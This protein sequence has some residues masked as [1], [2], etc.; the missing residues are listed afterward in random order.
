MEDAGD[1][2]MKL[3]GALSNADNESSHSITSHQLRNIAEAS[4]TL[5]EDEIEEIDLLQI[6][7]RY[8]LTNGY[9]KF[10]REITIIVCSVSFDIVGH[11]WLGLWS[12]NA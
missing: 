7:K 4:N 9:E 11:I 8:M 2:N 12:S 10:S 1:L 3:S 6:W 5:E